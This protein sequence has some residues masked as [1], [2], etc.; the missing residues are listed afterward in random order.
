[1]DDLKLCYMQ[2]KTILLLKAVKMHKPM[3]PKIK[4]VL[5]ITMLKQ[6]M[7]NLVQDVNLVVFK[8]IYLLAFFGFFRLASLTPSHAK[9][10][11]ATK[12]PLVKDIVWTID[13]LQFILKFEKNMQNSDEFKIK[14][15]CPVLSFIGYKKVN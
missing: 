7:L 3:K 8:A 15:S 1:M 9:L 11:N 2:E 13:G 5:S 4:G 10:F 14:K 6:L 12:F